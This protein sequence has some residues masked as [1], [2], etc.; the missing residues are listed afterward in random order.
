MEVLKLSASLLKLAPI[1][2]ADLTAE[3]VLRGD[4][5]PTALQTVR[6]DS[7]GHFYPLKRQK[8][9]VFLKIVGTGI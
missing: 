2:I 5:Q 7:L 1:L 9:F 3:A 4:I 8:E 6:E